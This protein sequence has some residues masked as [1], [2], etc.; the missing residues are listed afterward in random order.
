MRTV[1]V[2]HYS[3]RVHIFDVRDANAH[4]VD[5]RVG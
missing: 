4:W 1:E 5:S 3:L 2:R